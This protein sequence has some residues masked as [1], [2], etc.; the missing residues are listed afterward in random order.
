MEFDFTDCKSQPPATVIQVTIQ[1]GLGFIIRHDPITSQE[2]QNFMVSFTAALTASG[3]EFE[4]LQVG[5]IYVDLRAGVG[6]DKMLEQVQ[7]Y[8]GN[9]NMIYRQT[10]KG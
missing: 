2:G 6:R 4:Q 9:S 7:S 3:I 5:G 1:G 10:L 8:C